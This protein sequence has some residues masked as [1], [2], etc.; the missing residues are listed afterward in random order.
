MGRGNYEY[1]VFL[2]DDDMMFLTCY[3]IKTVK[4]IGRELYLA[5]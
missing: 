5:T 4:I 3:R 1:V 2:R